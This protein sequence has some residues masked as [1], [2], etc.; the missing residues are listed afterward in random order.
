MAK[1]KAQKCV[2]QFMRTTERTG[3]WRGKKTDEYV[4]Y[5]K[6]RVN[7]YKERE[8]TKEYI[9]GLRKKYGDTKNTSSL[10]ARDLTMLLKSIVKDQAKRPH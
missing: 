2:I 8:T 1:D 9:Q 3:K 7:K 5:Q 10:I 6:G 4:K